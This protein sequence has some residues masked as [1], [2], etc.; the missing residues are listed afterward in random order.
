[1]SELF[2]NV[3]PREEWLEIAHA[4]STLSTAI[5]ST[6]PMGA[7][8]RGVRNWRPNCGTEGCACTNPYAASMYVSATF[9]PLA[10]CWAEDTVPLLAGYSCLEEIWRHRLRVLRVPYAGGSVG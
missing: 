7:F 3:R 4:G 1:L 9:C 8:A 5:T 6:R 2:N 10:L